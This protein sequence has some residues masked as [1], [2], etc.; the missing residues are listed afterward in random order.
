MSAPASPLA[1]R[2]SVALSGRRALLALA[3]LGWAGCSRREEADPYDARNFIG[4]WRSTRTNT[5]IHLLDNGEWEIRGPQGEVMQF[6]VWTYD[7]RRLIWSHKS[8]AQVLH[9]I[10]LLVDYQ[11]ATFKVREADGSVTTFTRLP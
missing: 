11:R 6:G 9:D 1:A 10:T 3:G 5:P 4:A 2:A 8:G 7:R